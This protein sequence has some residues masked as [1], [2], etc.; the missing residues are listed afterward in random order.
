MKQNR[1]LLLS[2]LL[3][4]ACTVVPVNETDQDKQA[5]YLE[6]YKLRVE[7]M[8]AIPDWS[9]SG[10]LSLDDGDQGGSGKLQWQIASGQSTIDFHGAMGRGAWHLESG[11]DYAVLKLADGNEYSAP[12]VDTLVKRQVGWPIPVTALQWWVRGVAAPG[13]VDGREFGDDGLLTRLNQFGWQIDFNRYSSGSGIAM[14]TRLD[15]RQ[16][17]YRVKLAIGRWTLAGNEGIGD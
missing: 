9:L 5:T 3:L 13:P 4:N 15:A 1:W 14:P 2:L 16:T 6:A 8:D 7:T 11:P 17:N 12:A 10:R